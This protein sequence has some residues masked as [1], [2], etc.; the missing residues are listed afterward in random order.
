MTTNPA[1]NRAK[2]EQLKHLY[3][4]VNDGK[5]LCCQCL[6]VQADRINEASDN[7]LA[8]GFDDSGWFVLST[9]K[10]LGDLTLR[11]SFCQS[12]IPTEDYY[13]EL[14]PRPKAMTDEEAKAY[15]QY[16]ES[17]TQEQI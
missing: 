6:I 16:Y 10:N 12:A 9:D 11:C 7:Y 1:V 13:S 3:G 8:T 14:K 2:R 4:V 15:D 17:K 5:V